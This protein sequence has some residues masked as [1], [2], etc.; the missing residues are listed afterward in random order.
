MS[1]KIDL[2]F[3]GSISRI[4][5][6]RIDRARLY[7]STR[8]IGLD[9]KGRECTSALLTR[10]GKYVMGPGSTAGMYL[11]KGCDVIAREDLARMDEHGQPVISNK[12]EPDGPH[13]L[14][15]PVPMEALLE[16]AVTAVYEVDISEIDS[17][18]A[19][20]LS[21]GDIYHAP[22][23]GFL[24]A[25]EYGVFLLATERV[26]FDFIGHDQQIVIDDD[27]HEYDDLGFKSM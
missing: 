3:Q 13:E 6:H 9:G 26:R 1:R 27:D 16:C 11:N 24:L 20:S 25:N 18:L 19:A 4:A 14:A 8:R 12:V 5:L 15:G 10:D 2:S 17:T 23:R 22:N 7:G 21:R